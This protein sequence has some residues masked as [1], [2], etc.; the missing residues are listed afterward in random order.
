M[1]LDFSVGMDRVDIRL[2]WHKFD[3]FIVDHVWKNVETFF[4]KKTPQ[5]KEALK[6]NYCPVI[7]S[8]DGY[9][10][11]LKTKCSNPIVFVCEEGHKKGTVDDIHK[12]CHGCPIISIDRIWL[13]GSKFGVTL[14]TA[15][16]MVFPKP[17]RTV[18]DLFFVEMDEAA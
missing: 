16:L 3:D 9:D 17:E 14:N 11:I 12:G 10:P 6:D 7:N 1:C 18:E 2:F 8:K 13:M 15:A 5:T 4:P